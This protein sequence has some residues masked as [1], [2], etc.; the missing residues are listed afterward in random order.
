MA[1]VCLRDTSM[2]CRPPDWLLKLFKIELFCLIY[3]QP[4]SD[5]GRDVDCWRTLDGLQ[6]Q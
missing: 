2:D 4:V 6:F 3:F 1:I 5:H